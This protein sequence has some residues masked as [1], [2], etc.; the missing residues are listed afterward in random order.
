MNRNIPNRGNKRILPYF[1]MCDCFDEISFVYNLRELYF[2]RECFIP[3]YSTIPGFSE[4]HGWIRRPLSFTKNNLIY[5]DNN[6]FTTIVHDKNMITNIDSSIYNY[7][8][9]SHIGTTSVSSLHRPSIN[10]SEDDKSHN[11]KISNIDGVPSM[12]S[13]LSEVLCLL[14]IFYNFIYFIVLFYVIYFC[15][16]CL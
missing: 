11:L 9:E 4:N 10:S 16:Y 8:S 7:K 14:N 1:S 15:I 5:Y 6:N 13:I 12:W 2:K 3:A